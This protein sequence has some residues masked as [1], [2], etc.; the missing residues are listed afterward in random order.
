MKGW[1]VKTKGHPINWVDSVVVTTRKKARHVSTCSLLKG[2]TNSSNCS[3]KFER[4]G[5]VTSQ[6]HRNL[7]SYAFIFWKQNL[8]IALT[9]VEEMKDVDRLL[10]FK[11][12]MR[13]ISMIYMKALEDKKE[14]SKNIF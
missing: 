8:T 13:K 3:D 14:S 2:S 7:D 12:D 5:G 10:D 11:H 6:S 4:Q 9:N 1:I